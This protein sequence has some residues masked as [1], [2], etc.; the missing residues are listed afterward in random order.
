M[1][2]Y[3]AKVI[4]L[5]QGATESKTDRSGGAVIRVQDTT[6]TL[7]FPSAHQLKAKKVPLGVR[8]WGSTGDEGDMD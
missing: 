8:R 6:R 3:T 5:G 1:L 4:S 2:P 7:L